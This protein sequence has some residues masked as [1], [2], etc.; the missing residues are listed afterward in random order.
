M[1]RRVNRQEVGSRAIRLAPRP[2]PVT[3]ERCPNDP[4]ASAKT[5]GPTG[6]Q[7]SEALDPANASL[8]GMDARGLRAVGRLGLFAVVAMLVAL[9]IYK[10][11]LV[12][13]AA[14]NR[15][16]AADAAL[17]A[18]R[19]KMIEAEKERR[20]SQ[21]REAVS[22][23]TA[24]LRILGELAAAATKIINDPDSTDAER[25][26]AWR[27]WSQGFNRV[28]EIQEQLGLTKDADR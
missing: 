6:P 24:E 3:G 20:I 27:A 1:E 8:G 7:G 18:N 25:T 14:D 23:A 16:R 26:A 2:S 12:T 4:P 11:E 5:S 9:G 28:K 19:D 17:M 21:A 22:A 13:I 10:V 15:L